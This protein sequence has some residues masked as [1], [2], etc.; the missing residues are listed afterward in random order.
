V[1]I[2]SAWHRGDTATNTISG[3]SMAAP[4]VAGVA[5]LMLEGDGAALPADVGI[6]LLAQATQNLVVDPQGSPNRLLFSFASFVD[7]PLPSLSGGDDGSGTD[8]GDI[9]DDNNGGN[10]GQ[11]GATA[12]AVQSLEGRAA[13][14]RN[15]WKATAIVR[16]TAGGE[17]LDGVTVTGSFSIGG[18]GKCDTRGGACEI[19]SGALQNT[20]ASTRFTVESLSSGGYADAGGPRCVLIAKDG[21]DSC[22]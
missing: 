5:A 2:T 1:S 21:F 20:V 7:R 10:D 9:A 16:V 3:T 12:M 6:E 19:T 11:E 14:G 15:N 8:P 17:P 13:L 22:P 18:S 4:H